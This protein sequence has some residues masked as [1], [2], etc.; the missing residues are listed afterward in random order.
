MNVLLALEPGTDIDNT[1][2]PR[3]RAGGCH[4]SRLV[5]GSLTV[6][7]A[8]PDYPTESSEGVYEADNYP[9]NIDSENNAFA[10]SV[11]TGSRHNNP[12]GVELELTSLHD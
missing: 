10:T 7:V 9:V 5:T 12:Y 4:L 1:P 11:S 6:S 3:D 2:E 8:G